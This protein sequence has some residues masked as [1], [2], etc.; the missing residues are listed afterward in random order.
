[1]SG[2][3]AFEASLRTGF[4]PQKPKES[5]GKFTNYNAVPVNQNSNKVKTKDLYRPNVY[6][7]KNTKSAT[8]L[9][10]KDAD[11]EE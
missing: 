8:L 4:T 1:M 10:N 5:G 2:I 9:L 11:R 3:G 7:A 6:S